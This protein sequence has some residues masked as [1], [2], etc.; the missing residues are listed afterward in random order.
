MIVKHSSPSHLDPHIENCYHE[1]VIIE[2]H[3]KHDP[4]FQAKLFN[5][6]PY[7]CHHY[8][9]HRICMCETCTCFRS[10]FTGDDQPYYLI[11]TENDKICYVKEGMSIISIFIIQ[12]FLMICQLCKICFHF[13][14]FSYRSYRE[15]FT[16]RD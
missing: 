14:F 5:M 12:I 10:D 3:S 1:G 8:K 11:L 9:N 2:W 6:F 7:L 4:N 16:K 13:F 15:M